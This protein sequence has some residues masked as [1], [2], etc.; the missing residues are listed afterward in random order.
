MQAERSGSPPGCPSVTAP[1]R[2]SIIIMG[3]C[4]GRP[5]EP[6][7]SNIAL[8]TPPPSKAQ[9]ATRSAEDAAEATKAAAE[10]ATKMAKEAN[11]RHAAA[12]EA[13]AV[14]EKE[15]AD[16]AAAA[17]EEPK[18]IASHLLDAKKKFDALDVDGSGALAPDLTVESCSHSG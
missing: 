9:L 2:P 7:L 13:A 17:V 15:E 11:D 5:A 6:E 18:V 4:A 14:A 3:C 16:A 8:A 12:S 1:R 10:R